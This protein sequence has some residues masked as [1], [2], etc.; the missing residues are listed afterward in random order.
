MGS[1]SATCISAQTLVSCRSTDADL[2]THEFHPEWLVDWLIRT[3][4]IS[5][6]H[7]R[8]LGLVPRQVWHLGDA[9]VGDTLVTVVF[10]RRS[11]AKPISINSHLHCVP[12]IR[13][14]KVL[15]I[16]TSLTRCASGR[17]RAGMSY[18]LLRKLSGTVQDG[19][20]LDTMRL[21]SW[22]KGM[23][24]TTAKGALPGTG[25]PSPK[26][27]VA[28]IF[29]LRRGRGL[30]VEN[31]LAEARAIL[32]RMEPP[33]VG[34]EPTG[35]LDRARARGSLAKPEASRVAC[36]ILLKNAQLVLSSRHSAVSSLSGR[37]ARNTNGHA[38]AY[39]RS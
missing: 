34:S 37:V 12:S 14:T 31:D 7:K 3:L 6:P 35:S 11:L 24:A 17:F 30:R 19:L 28:Q 10:A 38:N 26:A 16:T 39:I 20:S 8:G 23:P 29:N 5:S 27:L 22:I 15:V 9:N 32:G 36:S 13:P 18:S 4:P 2:I 25:G 1:G 21:G 33:C